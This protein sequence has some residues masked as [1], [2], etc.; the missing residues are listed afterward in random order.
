MRSL[1][2]AEGE[3]F[4]SDTIYLAKAGGAYFKQLKIR[5]NFQKCVVRC[6]TMKSKGELCEYARA[7]G[8]VATTKTI[9]PYVYIHSVYM[10]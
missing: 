2:F 10:Q 8:D 4:M 7:T 1:L 3:I 9:C 5:E 6:G